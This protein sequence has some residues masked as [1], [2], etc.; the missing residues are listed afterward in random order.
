[1]KK[2]VSVTAMALSLTGCLNTVSLPNSNQPSNRMVNL[3]D[4]QKIAF[5]A[6]SVKA[7]MCSFEGGVLGTEWHNFEAN[8]FSIFMKKMQIHIGEQ[9]REITTL[10]TGKLLIPF[11]V[12]RN[13]PQT[14][15]SFQQYIPLMLGNDPKREKLE[16]EVVAAF[17]R[18]M[19]KDYCSKQDLDWNKKALNE[20]SK[21]WD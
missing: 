19:P 4:E 20:A 13:I 10:A 12:E 6:L 7:F 2:L 8:E 17:K 3:S 14:M 16:S 9:S 1:M 18:A 11:F 21:T 15:S 5:A